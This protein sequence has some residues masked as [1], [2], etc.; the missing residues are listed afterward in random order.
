MKATSKKSKCA[1]RLSRHRLDK[2]APVAS[3]RRLGQ[4]TVEKNKSSL[5]ANRTNLNNKEYLG[6]LLV[7]QIANI[8]RHNNRQPGGDNADAQKQVDPKRIRWLL[9]LKNIIVA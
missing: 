5:Q 2:I 9:L 1:T 3:R 8:R 6:R 4:T 7:I